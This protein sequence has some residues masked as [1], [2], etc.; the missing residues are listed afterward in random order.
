MSACGSCTLCCTLKKVEFPDHT[1]PEFVRC[2]FACKGCAIYEQRPQPC[3][4]YE[5]LWLQSQARAPAE[6]M[7]NQMRP[8]RSGVILEGNSKGTIVATCA[9]PAAWKREPMRS[10]LLNWRGRGATVLIKNRD[11][12]SLLRFD[13]TTEDL[14]QFG[15]DPET[16]ENLY[17]RK[18]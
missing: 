9:T 7:P 14:E 3:R 4:D 11:G 5:C 16:N 2:E 17:R 1:K 15:V 13:G 18:A 10:K 6:R 12:A 8:D